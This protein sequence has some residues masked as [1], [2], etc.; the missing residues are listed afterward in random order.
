MERLR[1]VNLGLPKS[2]TTTLGKA[3]TE[4]GLHTVDHRLHKHLTN[5]PA[6][7][8]RFVGHV[9]YEGYF[10][11]G[12]PLAHLD[13]FDG[14]GEISVLH[15]G[16][17]AY[18]QMDAAIIEA[19]AIKHP[20]VRFVATWRD[21]AALSRSMVKWNNLVKRLTRNSIPGLPVG[22]GGSESDR[23]HWIENH[24]R[25]LDTVFGGDPIYL[26]L[27]VAD[28]AVA[29]DLGDHIGREIAWWG[30]ANQNPKSDA[31]DGSLSA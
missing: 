21:P 8:G 9:I 7:T 19:I 22:F 30:T 28:D 31:G 16:N 2:G 3:L 15:D 4:S 10:Q 12:D 24:Y 27:D 11:T 18:P 25:F 5:R 14:F 29:Q 20:G 6:L 13:E 26:R 17:P 23:L 1:V